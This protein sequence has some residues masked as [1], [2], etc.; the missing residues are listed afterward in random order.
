MRLQDCQ[1]YHHC[2][3]FHHHHQN[4]ILYYMRLNIVF[5]TQKRECGGCGGGD[6]GYLGS[7]NFEQIFNLGCLSLTWSQGIFMFP[8]QRV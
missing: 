5:N 1:N 6:R 3:H 8:P 2:N 7:V 4:L